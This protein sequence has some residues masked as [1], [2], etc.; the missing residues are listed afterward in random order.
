MRLDYWLILDG[1]R[2]IYS[3]HS[4]LDFDGYL[5]SEFSKEEHGSYLNL[6]IF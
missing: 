4:S 1:G 6:T 3:S 2:G 5:R